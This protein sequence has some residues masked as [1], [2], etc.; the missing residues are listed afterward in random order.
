MRI[1][2]EIRSDDEAEFIGGFPPHPH[3]GIETPEGVKL[4]LRPAGLVPRFAAF[5]IDF[6]IRATIYLIAAQ[7]EEHMAKQ[8]AGSLG[9]E[10]ERMAK[11]G[12]LSPDLWM[13]NATGA[14]IQTAP[15]L[16]MTEAALK[17][18]P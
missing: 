5:A 2:N 15:L 10:F 6:G 14:P 11:L 9:K 16:R 18:L 1:A 7:I 17:A 12:Q 13:K 4:A 3:R 8:P